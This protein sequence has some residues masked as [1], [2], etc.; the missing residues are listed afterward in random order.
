MLSGTW[1]QQSVKLVGSGATGNAKQGRSVAI[2]NDG[3]TILVG[4]SDDNGSI[5]A[6]WVWVRSAGVWSQQGAKLTGASPV[7]TPQQGRAVALSGD[8]N[9]AMVGGWSDNSNQGAVWVWTRSAGTWTAQGSKMVG[10]GGTATGQQGWSVSL[11]YDGNTAAVGANADNA[12]VGAAWIWTRS[13]STWMQQ[14]NKLVGTAVANSKIGFSVSLSA[15]GNK[16][17]VGGAGDPGTGVGATWIFTRSGTTWTQFGSKLIASDGSATP[18]QG[19]SVS[20]SGDGT[21]LSV[22]GSGDT[23]GTGAV[24][25]WTA[26][27]NAWT[28]QGTSLRVTGNTGA[29]YRQVTVSISG[30]GNTAIAGVPQ[31]NAPGGSVWAFTRSNGVW[32]QQAG[33]FTCSGVGYLQ[34]AGLSVALSTDGTTAIIGVP[35]EGS[36]GA[37]CM[38]T[39][40]GSTWTQQSVFNQ[41]G[42]ITLG[43]A[44]AISSDG[45]TAVGGCGTCEGV[46]VWTRTGTTWTQQGSKLLGS[47]A[48]SAHQGNAVALSADGNTLLVGGPYNSANT[49]AA[50]VWTRS[51][52]LWTQQGAKLVGSGF[53]AMSQ[54]GWS[55]ALSSDGNTA[56]VGASGY[57]NNLIGAVGVWVRN[58][59][60]WSQQAGPLVGTGGSG[61][62]NQGISVALSA[63]GNTAVVGG[64][65]DTGGI[66]AIWIWTRSGNTWT[67]QGSKSVG[68]QQTGVNQQGLSVA[69]S[70]DGST[71][72]EGGYGNGGSSGAPVFWAFSG[73][74]SIPTTTVRVILVN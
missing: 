15:D 46:L 55:V 73:S 59:T 39:H 61:T 14:G 68:T 4:G 28:Q 11:S 66:G 63:Y 51:A 32:S 18:G 37:V 50:W 65:N 47:G 74:S 8:G 13:G 49:G 44:V 71:F 45:N 33:P 30:D 24:W 72:V 2:S 38:Y 57:S 36:N 40:S 19:E 26:P 9:T 43:F 17:A 22:G 41:S 3:N 58:G 27:A 70:G 56:L 20:M 12:W 1:V 42:N 52:G 29:L 54:L 69:V 6:A 60:I 67:Q 16:V 48:S 31:D 5:G 62:P 25:I 10:T 64:S 35:T 34:D 53:Q 7:G 21:T 23:S